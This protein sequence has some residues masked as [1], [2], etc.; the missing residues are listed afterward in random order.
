MAEAIVRLGVVRGDQ[1][2]TGP[3]PPWL[4]LEILHPVLADLQRPHPIGLVVQLEHRADGDV[5]VFS[6]KGQTG[7]YGIRVPDPA[8]PREELIVTWADLLQEQFFPE[9]VGAW[10]DARPECPGHPHPAQAVELD[11]QAWWICPADGRRIARIGRLAD[12]QSAQREARSRDG[13]V[14][15]VGTQAD[16]DWIT[17]GTESGRRV[18]AAIPP[19]YAAYAT[20]TNLPGAPGLPREL[21]M[22]RRQDLAFVEVLRRHSNDMAW[23]IAYL[24]TGASDIVFWDAPK[25]TLYED[26][27][28]VFVLAGPEQAASW[29]PA[30][31]GA[32]NWKSTE[33][34][35]VIFPEDRS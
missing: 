21:G 12:Q 28:Y 3:I 15:R 30:P 32:P 23:W 25:V 18:T 22:E 6:E 35:E 16:V 26:W 34:P 13:A 27:R 11:G 29:R 4:I 20:L 8:T 19:L 9:S 17:N 31:G 7:S 24:D 33:L 5:A 2:D 14:W 1:R 10:G